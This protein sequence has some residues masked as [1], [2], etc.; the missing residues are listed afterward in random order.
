MKNVIKKVNI[1]TEKRGLEMLNAR[2]HLGVWAQCWK[3]TEPPHSRSRGWGS[4]PRH[5]PRLHR[6]LRLGAHVQEEW[7]QY[8]LSLAPGLNRIAD[9]IFLL[10]EKEVP[11]SCSKQNWFRRDL[12]KNWLSVLE[13]M[14]FCSVGCWAL[15]K[16]C[17]GA[18]LPMVQ[19]IHMSPTT[20]LW[21]G[22]ILFPLNGNT[23]PH[24]RLAWNYK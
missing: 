7:G 18:E 17:S 16:E 4:S 5:S 9:H 10:V 14:L 6:Q 13:N 12:S 2:I 19:C 24:Q 20:Q 8:C 11:P 15:V 21:G 23:K 1:F 22:F 3:P